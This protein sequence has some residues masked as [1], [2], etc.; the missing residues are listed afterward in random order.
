MAPIL[1]IKHLSKHFVGVQAIFDLSFEV[2][3]GR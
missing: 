2:K 3:R 1:E